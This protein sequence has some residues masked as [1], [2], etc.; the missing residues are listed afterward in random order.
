[1]R[2]LANRS[3]QLLYILLGCTIII[4]A[5]IALVSARTVNA[6]VEHWQPEGLTQVST[7]SAFSCGLAS[8]K[9]YC[10]GTN[11]LGQFGNGTTEN[12]TV[13]VAV[14]TSGVLAGKTVT[15]IAAKGST[16][17]AIADTK[18]YCW[19]SRTGDGT[20]DHSSVPVAVAGE[21]G[22]KS[23]TA[24][25]LGDAHSCALAEGSVYCWGGN[26]QGQLGN[27]SLEDSD[28]PALVSVSGVLGGKNIT[29][30]SV[31]NESTCVIADSSLYCW[32]D[33][34][35]GQL[36]DG[37]LDN[38][39]LP[40]AVD[41]S[42]VLAGKSVTK[43]SMGLQHGCVIADSRPYCWGANSN[44][45][46]GAGVTSAL[47]SSPVA[48]DVSGVLSGKTISAINAYYTSCVIADGQPYCWGLNVLDDPESNLGYASSVPRLVD[49][50]GVLST[51]TMTNISVG[52]FFV[53]AVADAKPYCWGSNTFGQ[54]GRY[55]ITTGDTRLSP[56]LVEGSVSAEILEVKFSREGDTT[57]LTI[58]GEALLASIPPD[59]YSTWGVVDYAPLQTRLISL[60][61]D[62]LPFCADDALLVT[63]QDNP[64]L[65]SP[66]AYST[67]PPCYE[68]FNDNEF[69]EP[70]LNNEQLR[71]RL[72]SNY[73]ITAAG[74]VQ[75]I[76]G[77]KF[78]FNQI[79]DGGGNHNEVATAFVD[80]NPIKQKTTIHKRPTFTG[81]AEPGAH[82]KVE[83]RSDP[84]IC[85][86]TADQNGNWSCTFD[87]DIPAGQHTVRVFVTN[88]DNSTQE[89]GPYMVNVPGGM[90]S[91]ILAPNTGVGSV[92][93]RVVDNI[94]ITLG[95]TGV[96]IIVSTLL[97]KKRSIFR[98]AR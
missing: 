1:M 96:V 85:E 3:R 82:I 93:S 77:T 13:P 10:W 22:T 84:I 45:Q 98:S 69:I 41:T 92:G 38:S 11:H 7:G 90:L 39:A 62:P 88:P 31:S 61:G 70:L 63:L 16:V 27:G 50:S 81:V 30:V 18:L 56:G 51:K 21:L 12:S 28:A 59:S 2:A 78:A 5:C 94:W 14:D 44:G 79:T 37:T 47:S 52:D 66:Q 32:G 29:A 8:G 35:Y 24:V 43:L 55:N 25:A 75:I 6:A 19:G 65:V 80:G 86:T 68:A 87:Q 58:N 48:V 15:S 34:S 53:C 71:I 89:L 67:D 46:L 20:A 23:V 72:P 42:G 17:C 26:A 4:S 49:E 74:D 60:N 95:F 76:G 83:I 97:Y 91:G 40:V 33:N 9:V 64:G 73:D 54:L 57:I 36:G